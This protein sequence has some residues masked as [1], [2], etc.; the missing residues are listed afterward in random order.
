[1]KWQKVVLNRKK[2]VQG[3]L[4]GIQ[5]QFEELFSKYQAP[6]GMALFSRSLSIGDIELYF[7][8]GSSEYALGLIDQY[9]GVECEKPDI[10]D[11]ALLV[12]HAD[13]AQRLLGE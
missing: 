3:D 10:N 5:S 9:N 2:V 6:Q 8:P 1:M 13:S 11:L 4:K 7:S 12:G